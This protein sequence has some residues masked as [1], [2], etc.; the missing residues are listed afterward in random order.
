MKIEL[1]DSYCHVCKTYVLNH[2]IK[3]EIGQD[4]LPFQICPDCLEKAIEL[5]KPYDLRSSKLYLI[6]AF[7][8]EIL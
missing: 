5:I 2:V 3:F 6:G 4:C 8:T 7:S 1:K